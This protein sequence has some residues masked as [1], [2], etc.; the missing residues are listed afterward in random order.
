[1]YFLICRNV[2][3]DVTKISKFS[4]LWKTKKSKYLYKET[5]FFPLVKKLINCTF[6]AIL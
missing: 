4:D 5:Q 2:Y 1:M 3:D 6:R